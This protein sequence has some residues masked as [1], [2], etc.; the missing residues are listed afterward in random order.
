[1]QRTILSADATDECAVDELTGEYSWTTTTTTTTTIDSKQ[2]QQQ[3]QPTPEM[4][5]A[6]TADRTCRVGGSA[7]AVALQ[8]KQLS[9]SAYQDCIQQF[10]ME[11]GD[12]CHGLQNY[13]V[14]DLVQGEEDEEEEEILI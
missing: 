14:A 11:F 4:H 1:M 5:I 13:R 7:V 8:K 6:I 9:Q 3:Q 10:Q 12:A 2:Q